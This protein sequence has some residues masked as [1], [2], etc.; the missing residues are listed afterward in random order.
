MKLLNPKTVMQPRGGYSQGVEVNGFVHVAG[1]VGVDAGGKL[2][3]DGSM[4][5]QTRQTLVNIVAILAEAGATLA[6]VV[7]ATVYVKDFSEYKLFDRIWQEYFGSHK[8]ARATVQAALVSPE[9][10]I[11]IQAVAVAPGLRQREQ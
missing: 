1:Q 4:E 2:T 7:S 6:D 10:L 8:P 3:G 5:A 11:E 9:L